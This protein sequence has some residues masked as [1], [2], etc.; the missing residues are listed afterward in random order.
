MVELICVQC[1]S[2]FKDYPG[3][4]RKVCSRKCAYDVQKVD[5]EHTCLW[6]EKTFYSKRKLSKYCSASCSGKN[7]TRL[8]KNRRGGSGSGK[9]HWNWKGGYSN[10]LH[11]LKRRV[12]V[13]NVLRVPYRREDIFE[14]D[15]GLCGICGEFIDRLLKNPHP[16]AF[17]VQHMVPVS[18]GGADAPWNLVSAHRICN[19]KMGVKIQTGRYWVGGN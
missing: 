16:K 4:N 13:L 3:N 17:T 18:K 11:A 2:T 6:C 15:E 12:G 1:K 14:R 8:I 9:D 19:L 7:A 5:H 10:R